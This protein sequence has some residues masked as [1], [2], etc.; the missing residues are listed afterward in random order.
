MSG[1]VKIGDET[2]TVP[3]LN[4]I[5]ALEALRL[6]QEIVQLAPDVLR[7][8]ATFMKEY[9]D[10]NYRE[11]DR[12]NARLEFPPLPLVDEHDQPI[13]GDDGKVLLV[14]GP[15]DRMTEA[16]WEHVGHVIKI[17][18][19][20]TEIEVGAELAPLLM[21]KAI[22]PTMRLM[23]LVVASNDQ[24]LE[25]KRAGDLEAFLL[26]QGEDLFHR[27]ELEQLIELAVVAV[28]TAN[29]Q[30]R[31]K[32]DEL[33]DRLGNVLSAFGRQPGAPT[34]GETETPSTGSSST[35]STPSPG[36]TAGTSG[37]SSEPAG[38]SS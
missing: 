14:E 6:T 11:I 22:D 5:K 32:L 28:E 18:E 27:G 23:A 10:A 2:V 20:P 16:D 19:R 31:R 30:V 26:G 33:G 8:R 24:V 35:S 29:G 37:R 25:H 3:T 38:V 15:F 4:G 13:T 36:D 7:R 17:R 21:D 34:S 9:G 12:A 1:H